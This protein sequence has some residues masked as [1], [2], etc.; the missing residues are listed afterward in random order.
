MIQVDLPAA[1]AIGQIFA[2]L[3]H[4]YLSREPYLF[5][6]RLM[7]PFNLVMSCCFAPGGVFLLVAW[8]AW[9]VMYQTSWFEVPYDR[10]LAAGAYVLFG[11]AMVMLGNFGFILAHHW[12]RT[13]RRKWVT[14]GAAISVALTLLPFVLRW[15]VWMKVG[16]YAEVAEGDGGRS[17]WD[18]PFV[19]GWA[20]IMSYLVVSLLIAGVAFKKVSDRMANEMEPGN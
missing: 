17:F 2:G 20:M 7:G 8:P 10:P 19:T 18:P 4:R 3:S 16:T 9:E 12:I 6:N 15:G 14:W 5:T 13:G 11:I 1:I